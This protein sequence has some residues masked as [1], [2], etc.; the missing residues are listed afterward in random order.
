[1]MNCIFNI[2]NV[3]I[4]SISGNA[5]INLGESTISSPSVTTKAQGTTFSVGD[6]APISS[7][8][9]NGW[10]DQDWKDQDS[11]LSPGYSSQI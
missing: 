6:G 5:S 4:N 3:K 2:A 10:A 11:S 8:T 9:S 7:Q 1:M